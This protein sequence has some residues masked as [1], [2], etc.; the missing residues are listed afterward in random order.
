MN[1][2]DGF[3]PTFWTGKDVSLSSLWCGFDCIFHLH[4]LVY[5]MVQ[6]YILNVFVAYHIFKSLAGKRYTFH[7]AHA[8][9]LESSKYLALHSDNTESIWDQPWLI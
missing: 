1:G 6:Q 5:L 7:I 9:M 4:V 3:I 2:Q 8:Q